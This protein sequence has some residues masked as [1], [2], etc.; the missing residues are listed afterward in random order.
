MQYYLKLKSANSNV[1]LVPKIHRLL[2][3]TKFTARKLMKI[4]FEI[5][6]KENHHHQFCYSSGF[7]IF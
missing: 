7:H 1:T 4:L 5:Q 3:L 6:F 2:T